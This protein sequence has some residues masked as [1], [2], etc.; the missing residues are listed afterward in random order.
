MSIVFSMLLDIVLKIIDDNLWG[1]C[2]VVF[3]QQKQ[4]TKMNIKTLIITGKQWFDRVNGNSYFSAR[5]TVNFGL[6]DE[7]F[8]AVPF[9]YG[10]DSQFEYACYQRLSESTGFDIIALKYSGKIKVHSD[11]QTGCTKKEVKAFSN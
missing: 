3:R 6:P 2:I 4:P 10:Y 5:C 1:K 9:Q 7:Y 8:F 11:L